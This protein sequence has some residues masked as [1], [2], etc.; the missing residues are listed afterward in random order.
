MSR[1][2]LIKPAMIKMKNEQIRMSESSRCMGAS[3]SS[4]RRVTL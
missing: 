4:R 3:L 2:T 1:S